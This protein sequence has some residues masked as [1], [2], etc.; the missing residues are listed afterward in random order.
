MK[1]A[2]FSMKAIIGGW[3]PACAGMTD[4]EGEMTCA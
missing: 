4:R 2:A 1:I 3:V